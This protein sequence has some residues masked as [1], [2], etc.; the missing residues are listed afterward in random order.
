VY[1]LS[2]ELEVEVALHENKLTKELRVEIA[3]HESEL[4]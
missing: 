1:S 4:N 3:L 2:T